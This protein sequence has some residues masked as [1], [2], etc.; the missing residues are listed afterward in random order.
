MIQTDTFKMH[1]PMKAEICVLFL[2]SVSFGQCT[3]K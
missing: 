2:Y 1:L 3:A